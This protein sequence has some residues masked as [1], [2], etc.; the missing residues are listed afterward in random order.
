MDFVGLE[1]QT[2]IELFVPKGADAK[3]VSRF[4][5]VATAYRK[6]DR[7]NV[8]HANYG[9]FETVYYDHGS[10]PLTIAVHH[11]WEEPKTTVMRGCL[12]CL[13]LWM[14][15]KSFFIAYPDLTLNTLSIVSHNHV[16]LKPYHYK[17][18]LSEL[19]ELVDRHG[20]HLT[21]FHDDR[22]TAP[23]RR[24]CALSD[25]CPSQPPIHSILSL[26]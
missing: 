11:C 22:S 18:Q 24:S 23:S 25:T 2:T 15:G 20:V 4:L 14:C 16:Q 21:T 17:A 3:I 13:M 7:E 5:K 6:T 19:Q 8:K 26:F 9:V 10:R 12:T 1:S